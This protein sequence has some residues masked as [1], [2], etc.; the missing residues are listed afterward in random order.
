MK[1]N[2]Q[3]TW[4]STK[5]DTFLCFYFQECDCNCDTCA[6]P[7]TNDDNVVVHLYQEIENLKRQIADRDYH[8][9]QMETSV[10]NH[11]KEYPNGEFATLEQT[12]RFWQEKYE[13]LFESHRKLQKV[14]QALEDKLLRIVDKFETEKSAMTR[15][16]A[17]LTTKLVEARVL[18][19]DLE[20]ENE[21]YKEDCNIAMQLL[22]CKPSNF[23]SH[24]VNTLPSDLQ[25]KVRF[26]FG[27]SNYHRRSRSIPV[28]LSQTSNTQETEAS[29]AKV[30]RVPMPT[31]PPTAMVYSINRSQQEQSQNNA[32]VESGTPDYVSAA[33]VAKILEERS[34]E[35][36]LKNGTRYQKCFQCRN[37]RV[38]CMYFDESSQT[39]N[40]V[41]TNEDINSY[42]W[43]YWSE[44]KRRTRNESA[45]SN[46]SVESLHM[47]PAATQIAT[48]STVKKKS[49]ETIII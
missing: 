15:D 24:K 29:S 36:N 32:D 11:A 20:D 38:S 1:A 19:T 2:H 12:L 18:I 23:V 39:T 6:A 41:I 40:G 43:N 8:I 4:R 13:R 25:E 14:N 46:T 28:G 48:Q 44:N 31:F 17:D 33:I 16:V 49:S 35:R 37:R 27:N 34:K 10:M 45:S 5:C 30:I 3:E 22:Q 26:H 42:P 9:V 47:M 7:K 21:Q